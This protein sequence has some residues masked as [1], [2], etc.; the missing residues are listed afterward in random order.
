MDKKN[1]VV[2]I[3]NDIR[4]D[5]GE[6]SISD[7]D[8]NK[9]LRADLGLDSMDLAVLTARIE[10]EYGIDIFEDGIV[11]TTAEILKKLG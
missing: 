5:K 6:K 7:I 8:T 4:E 3:I 10:E 2:S 9:D 11:A 1:I